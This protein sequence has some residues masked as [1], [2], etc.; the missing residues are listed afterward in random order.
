MKRFQILVVD[1]EPHM[2]WLLRESFIDDFDILGA[3]NQEEALAAISAHQVDAVLLDL[4]L[5]NEDGISVLKKIKQLAPAVPVIV[6]TAYASVP[7]AVEA[8][9]RGAYDYITKPFDIEELRGLIRRSLNVSG[10]TKL[11]QTYPQKVTRELSRNKIVAQ[12]S[13][14]L[15]VWHLVKKVAPTEASVLITGESGT[16]K[17][18]IAR[19]LHAESLRRNKPFIPINCAAL[20]ETL[21]ESE[22]F[23]Y[24]EGAF[25]GARGRKAGKFELAHGGTLLLDEIGDMPLSIQ[26]KILRVLEDKVVERLGSTRQTT[27]DV[28]IIASTNKNL[29]EMVNKNMF[30]E[31]LYFR[32]AVFPIHI[33]PLRERVEDI[34]TLAK[35]FL[36]TYTAKY[37]KETVK[38][39][40]P[41]VLDIF[42]RYRWPGNVRE[43][44]NLVEQLVILTDGSLVKIEN[45]PS[46][47]GVLAQPDKNSWPSGK[48]APAENRRPPGKTR[49][50]AKDSCRL[51]KNSAPHDKSGVPNL[52]KSRREAERQAIYEALHYCNGNRTKAAR[53]L[54]ISRRTLQLKLKKLNIKS[55]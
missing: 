17:E 48:D 18:L 31:D 11:I 45:L 5:Q 55:Y 41:A 3:K 14:M 16:G 38:D 22:L 37:Q 4:R 54:G 6:I 50:P 53:L 27:V 10:S 33:P 29:F 1:D 12:S 8:M 46:T 39:F 34:P 28:R 20:P 30:R 49:I 47:F 26:V 44:R 52:E 35:H 43:L 23:G 13:E 51:H 32:L 9:K 19:A 2:I 25:T 7:T 15:R 42:S 21:L 24:E 40:H 36:K